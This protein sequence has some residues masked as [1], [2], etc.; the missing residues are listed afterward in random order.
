MAKVKYELTEETKEINGVTLHR[1][2]RIEDGVLGGF[3]EKEEN[4]SQN[5]G[6]AWVEDEAC[7]YGNARVFG[8][9]LVSNSA[10]V[11]GNAEVGNRAKIYDNAVVK[12]DT[13][14]NGDAEIFGNAVLD[15]NIKIDG[16]V[17]IG[18]PFDKWLDDVWSN[19]PFT[20]KKRV[21]NNE[22]Q[23]MLDFVTDSDLRIKLFVSLIHGSDGADMRW[24]LFD[25]PYVEYFDEFDS[26]L[27]EQFIWYYQHFKDAV[28]N[29]ESRG[30]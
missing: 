17:K 6:N 22:L 2:K 9:A 23:E 1:I 4:L 7:V 25:S 19:A 12:G 24:I 10:I 20:D 18:V 15:L 30:F 28:M 26:D 3:I 11:C 29:D 5:R 27:A 14:I 16:D 13:E 21:N 8:N